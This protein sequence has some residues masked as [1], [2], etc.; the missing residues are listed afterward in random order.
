MIKPTVGRIV[1]YWP[2]SADMTHAGMADGHTQPLAALV[3]HV[4]SDSCVNLTIF[5][6]HGKSHSKTSVL[7]V[8]EGA[9]VPKGGGFCEW[10]AEK[11]D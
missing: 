11:A 3:A 9:P 4:W 2:C 7:L 6:A 10:I 5:D 1:H 8:Q